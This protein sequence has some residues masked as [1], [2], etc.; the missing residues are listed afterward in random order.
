MMRM[1]KGDEEERGHVLQVQKGVPSL[2]REVKFSISELSTALVREYLHRHGFASTLHCYDCE[3]E[4]SK[5]ILTSRSSLRKALSLEK[6]AAKAKLKSKDNSTP[7]SLEVMV[8]CHMQRVEQKQQL[9]STTDGALLS[10]TSMNAQHPGTSTVSNSK[11]SS[12]KEEI[13]QTSLSLGSRPLRPRTAHNLSRSER[14][15]DMSTTRNDIVVIEDIDDEL[16]DSETSSITSLQH[17]NLASSRG[18]NEGTT[19]NQ[20]TWR[21]ST[22]LLSK[23]NNYG[24]G[25]NS[26]A[27]CVPS[28]WLQGFFFR[29]HD[30]NRKDDEN[31]ILPYGLVQLE[32]G[33]CGILAAVQAH[34][35]KEHF[36][37]V[38]NQ[39]KQ[40]GKHNVSRLA[41]ADSAYTTQLL[42]KALTSILWQIGRVKHSFGA[43]L[44]LSRGNGNVMWYK[45]D[46][47]ASLEKLIWNNLPAITD[48]NGYGALILVMSAILSRGPNMIVKDM[49]DM[50]GSAGKLVG[51]HGYCTQELVNLLLIGQAVSNVFDG[52]KV[53]ESDTPSSTDEL[54]ELRGISSR[55]EIGFLTLFEW[56]K[57]VEV[58]SYF[59][60]PK[61]PVWVVCSESH[62]S[63]IF[64]HDEQF[65][66]TRDDVTLKV[67]SDS[68]P[69]I[70][71]YYD[72]LASQEKEIV[73]TLRYDPN[74][75]HTERCDER[76]NGAAPG[77]PVP[78]LEY[79][80]ETK[81][82]SVFVDWGESEQIL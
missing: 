18:L 22:M 37:N 75:G 38:N 66:S 3:L 68:E 27:A 56:Y 36:I 20:E 57:Y 39:E 67:K 64:L 32:G 63:T 16:I 2:E 61:Y 41:H 29:E 69:L 77:K 14:I 59:K 54:I 78:P 5:S 31:P 60:N 53:L 76:I 8:S 80:I 50:I 79:V 7:T 51:A 55:S 71:V 73:L 33:P 12:T 1:M 26:A 40:A 17:P 25:F 49:D 30:N 19:I 48:P 13:L 35:V 23:E 47:K 34:I 52:N 42:V 45:A 21:Q 10:R 24:G 46:T 43:G 70:M 28:S 74:G 4:S 44:V 9:L 72:G 82:P 15:P 6:Q 11:K 62:F 81:W 58:G 65:I